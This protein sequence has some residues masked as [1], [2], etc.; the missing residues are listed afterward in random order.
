MALF[1]DSDIASL[2]LMSQIDPEMNNVASLIGSTPIEGPGSICETAWSECRSKLEAA[3]ALY[4]TYYGC[5]GMQA[6]MSA[7]LNTGSGNGNRPR[8]RLNQ[9]VVSDVYY[10]N[11]LSPIQRW[12]TYSALKSVFQTAAHRVGAKK[13]TESD[14]YDAKRTFYEKKQDELWRQL[15]NQGMPA[16]SSYLD[17]PGAKHSYQ[18]GT[19]TPSNLILTAGGTSTAEL[20]V[21]VAITYFDATQFI[22][23]LNKNNSESGPSA[24]QSF[25]IPAG[26]LLTVD[27]NSLSPPD[28]NNPPNLGISQGIV[29][30]MGADGWNIYVGQPGAPLYLQTPNGIAITQKTYTLSGAPVLS[31]YQMDSGQKPL[32]NAIFG[33]IVQRG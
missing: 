29:P 15:M 3:L 18:S 1:T 12:V 17:G 25:T 11:S 33:Q 5:S 31:G 22:D 14:R 20:L 6:H 13:G 21:N 24:I 19:F 27:I 16:L 2:A 23:P 32:T 9:V 7:L 4:S 26:N 30:F 8:L 10:A 28:R